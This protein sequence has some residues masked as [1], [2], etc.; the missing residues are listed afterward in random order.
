MRAF[1]LLNGGKNEAN[2]KLIALS[3]YNLYINNKLGKI[4]YFI[5]NFTYKN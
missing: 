4:L 2:I 5:K 1:K 3:V